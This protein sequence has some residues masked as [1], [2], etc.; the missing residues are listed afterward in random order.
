MKK[1]KIICS[2]C[3]ILS[4]AIFFTG[5]PAVPSFA[6]FAEN[7]L[8]FFQTNEGINEIVIEAGEIA[9]HPISPEDL[10][11]DEG[12]GLD[13]SSGALEIGAIEVEKIGT[14]SAEQ[15]AALAR[16][17]LDTDL[18]A[19]NLRTAPNTPAEPFDYETPIEFL[20]DLT[21]TGSSAVSGCVFY[22]YVDGVLKNYYSMVTLE[23]NSVYN[24]SLNVIG[25]CGEHTIKFSFND[26]HSVY[27]TNYNNNSVEK[28][29]S[30]ED[31]PSIKA[32]YF[33]QSNNMTTFECNRNV[34][35]K[36]SI[37]NF[38]TVD[39][40]DIPIE[41]YE[42]DLN[43]DTETRMVVATY[44]QLQKGTQVEIPLSFY[45][46][47]A[48]DIK[49][50]V[51]V[52]EPPEGDAYLGDNIASTPELNITYDTEL[53]RGKWDNP[54][55]DI[56]ISQELI[57]DVVEH[58]ISSNQLQ[59]AIKNWNNISSNVVLTT[60]ILQ[61]PIITDLQND[62]YFQTHDYP[63]SYNVL[64]QTIVYKLVNEEATIIPDEEIETDNS[65]Y[66]YSYVYL[67]TNNLDYIEELEGTDFRL[68]V[69]QHEFGHVLSL[70]HPTCANPSI[71]AADVLGS[72]ASSTITGHDRYNVIRKYGE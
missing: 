40:T 62:V 66:Y 16:N 49:I 69:T 27:E 7:E 35:F 43:H 13:E 38:G 18:I 41:I 44:S 8:T 6:A 52:G 26:L 48:C 68:V 3:L 34:S 1:K 71:V 29:Y 36:L 5:I 60:H 31:V 45:I 10:L 67:Y 72:N 65:S 46:G 59:A 61:G 50:Q 19:S 23:P 14:L 54:D 33:R 37:A 22:F 47:K 15:Q 32:M 17:G 63:Y 25:N 20:C 30:W 55:L 57:D 24:V 2:I 11:V 12:G 28:E 70:K 21:V 58:N 42:I 51:R 53:W 56:Y 39:A 9:T 64:G 4:S